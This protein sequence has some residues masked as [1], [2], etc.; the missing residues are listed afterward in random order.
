MGILQYPPFVTE[1]GQNYRFMNFIFLA[2]IRNN[3]NLKVLASVKA[4][5]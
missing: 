5:D 2:S 4:Y 3:N 1:H